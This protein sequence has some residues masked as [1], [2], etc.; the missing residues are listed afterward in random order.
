MQLLS[1]FLVQLRTMDVVGC[2]SQGRI[3]VLALKYGDGRLTGR[4]WV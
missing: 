3:D 1:D 4:R 2:R